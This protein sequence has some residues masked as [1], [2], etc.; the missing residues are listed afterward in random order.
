MFTL[1]LFEILLYKR[2]SVMSPVQWIRGSGRVKVSVKN[3]RIFGICYNRFKS[4]LITRLGDFEWF[5]FVFDFLTLSI[6]SKSKNSNFEMAIVRQ[7]L[8]L[9]ML[10]T[11]STKSMILHTIK[12]LIKYSLKSILFFP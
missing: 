11:L 9:D 10:R 1:I 12:K 3:K 7:I 4:D 8:N 2:G 6:P 5:L